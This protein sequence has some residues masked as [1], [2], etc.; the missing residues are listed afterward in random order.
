MVNAVSRLLHLG[1]IIQASCELPSGLVEIMR[2][3]DDLAV[4]RVLSRFALEVWLL[5]LGLVQI[6]VLPVVAA[7]P[8]PF[9]Y[10]W[11]SLPQLDIDWWHRTPEGRVSVTPAQL[12]AQRAMDRLV[13]AQDLLRLPAS[14]N[15]DKPAIIQAA[16]RELAGQRLSPTLRLEYLALV[17]EFDT[18]GSQADK[19]WS[20]V[21]QEVVARGLVE[22]WLAKCK[23]PQANGVWRGRL[24]DPQVNEWEIGLA[25]KGLAVTGS[26]ADVAALTT[27]VSD[28]TWAL[29]I[30]LQAARAIGALAD[31][32]QLDLAKRLRESSSDQGDLLAIEVLGQRPIAAADQ[33]VI[34]VIDRGSGPAQCKAYAWLCACAPEIAIVRAQDYVAH[35]EPEVRRL[36]MQQ[37][38][39]SSDPQ[40]LAL[41]SARLNDSHPDLREM[42]RLQLLNRADSDLEQRRAIMD[43]V[44]RGMQTEAWEGLEHWIHLTVDLQHPDQEKRLL[45]LLEHPHKPTGVLAAWALRHRALS[46]DTWASM[47]EHAQLWTERIRNPPADELN[48]EEDLR[49]MAHL[50][51]AFGIKRY[52]PAQKMLLVYVPKDDQRMGM[53]TRM[54]GL[55]ACGRMWENSENK[56][57]VQQ[58]ITCISDKQSMFPEP[59]SVRFAATLALGWL[60]DPESRDA[61]VAQQEAPPSPIAPATQWALQR[62]K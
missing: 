31:S 36:S 55:W 12:Q 43:L 14:P 24:T 34:D 59:E 32:D 54:A 7:E 53:I 3:F 48:V 58:L 15:L 47:L 16:M 22:Q 23:Q 5:G 30:R 13:A 11:Q 60:A 19:L 49:R 28:K 40:V 10:A 21:Q 4:M 35:R 37:L 26:P 2:N 20:Q 52:A 44:A 18:T 27:V 33:L 39:R 29:G 50:L 56:P 8:V 61:V 1:M 42:A 17:C 9:E 25:L 6:V 57:L 41:L 46:E 45:E 38:S 62:M 51:E